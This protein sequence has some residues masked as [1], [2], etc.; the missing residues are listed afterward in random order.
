MVRGVVYHDYSI[1]SP[2]GISFI[3][4]IAEFN[5]EQHEGIAIIFYTIDCKHELAIT[6]HCCYHTERS[7]SLHGCNHIALPCKAPPMLSL[8]CL[9][10]NT[11]IN[12]DDDFALSHVFNV[13][14]CSQLQLKLSLLF[15]VCIIDGIYFLVGEP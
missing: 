1:L 15:V 6:A 10:E 4:M 13:V 5:Q 9:I 12:V 3:K 2:V 14:S 7:E 8:I 11:F